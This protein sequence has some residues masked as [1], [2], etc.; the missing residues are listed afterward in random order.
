MFSHVP[1]AACWMDEGL[2]KMETVKRKSTLQPEIPG[3]HFQETNEE[4]RFLFRHAVYSM[5]TVH[6]HQM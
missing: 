3:A 1:F 4:P 6:H 2:R 5:F